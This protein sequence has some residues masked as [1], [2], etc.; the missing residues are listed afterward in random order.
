M[1]LDPS[2]LLWA[3]EEPA[4]FLAVDY[5]RSNSSFIVCPL[6]YKRSGS[7]TTVIT[8]NKPIAIKSGYSHGSLFYGGMLFPAAFH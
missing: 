1:I 6:D 4:A 8:R 3:S 7:M 5:Q 2:V